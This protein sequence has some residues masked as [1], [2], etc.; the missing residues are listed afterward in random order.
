ML[1]ER[2]EKI[3]KEIEDM[4]RELETLPTGHLEV[5]KIN[6]NYYYYLRYWEDGKLK[7]KYIGRV[8]KDIKDKLAKAE[9]LRRKLSQLKEEE[10][11]IVNI[12]N[13]IEKIV[14]NY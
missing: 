2:V 4:E 1:E 5:K 8:A 6:G 14:S 10:K 7:S 11:R 12:L 3:K 13:K 9:D